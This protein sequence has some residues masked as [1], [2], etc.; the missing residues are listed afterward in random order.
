MVFIKPGAPVGSTPLPLAT[1][2][3]NKAKVAL[4]GFNQLGAGPSVASV[5]LKEPIGISGAAEQRRVLEN[6]SGSSTFTT[7]LLSLKTRA[8]EA[9]DV[10]KPAPSPSVS[11]LRK[12]FVGGPA[13]STNKSVASSVPQKTSGGQAVTPV[14]PMV[15]PLSFTSPGLTT[16]STLLSKSPI[17]S[18]PSKSAGSAQQHGSGPEKDT[19]W[20]S[21]T[22]AE[23]E[24]PKDV[25]PASG[26]VKQAIA[27]LKATAGGEGATVSEAAKEVEEEEEKIDA[28]AFWKSK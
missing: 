5:G 4:P 2:V 17:G 3:A 16:T 26:S 28:F 15:K 27:A 8:P 11:D 1:V 25:K 10:D 22:E 20:K 18:G 12:S 21:T 7:P 14:I 24:T 9:E 13:T 6:K 19:P 23:S